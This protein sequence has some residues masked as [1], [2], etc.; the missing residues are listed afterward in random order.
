MVFFG[1]K[2]TIEELE[3]ETRVHNSRKAEKEKYSTAL[4][5]RNTARNAGAMSA[6]GK[7]K[8]FGEK[9][10]SSGERF[11]SFNQNL[12]NMYGFE[13]RKRR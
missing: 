11:N 1:R 7:I 13:K 8:D 10:K 6:F 4:K 2:P 12:D 9:I 3:A 5:A